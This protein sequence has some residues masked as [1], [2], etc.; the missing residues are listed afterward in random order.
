M[1]RWFRLLQAILILGALALPFAPA[2]VSAAIL[3]NQVIVR[4]GDIGQDDTGYLWEIQYA[5]TNLTTWYSPSS[6]GGTGWIYGSAAYDGNTGTAAIHSGPL[7]GWSENF[8]VSFT[9][10][11]IVGLRF[12]VS[13][14]AKVAVD[15]Y[16]SNNG[17]WRNKYLGSYSSAWNVIDFSETVAT[18]GA[19]GIEST[20]AV[21]QGTLSS[22]GSYS[23]ASVNFQYGTTVNYGQ[24][25]PIETA[26]ATGTFTKIIS[27]LFPNTNYHYRAIARFVGT[28]ETALIFGGDSV[29][30]TQPIA[31]SSTDIRII[32]VGVFSSYITSGDMLFAIE[33]FNNYTNR[34]PHKLPG[35]SFTLQLVDTDNVT[36]LA[37]TP[38]PS[39]GDRPASIYL[40]PTTASTLISG[41]AYYIKMVGNADTSNAT[42]IHILV[43]NEWKGSDLTQLDQW[44]RGV[45]WNV[46]GSE[47]TSIWDKLKRVTGQGEIISD[48]MGPYFSVGIPGI[49]QIRPNLFSSSSSYPSGPSGTDNASWFT[50][51]AWSTYVGP[52]IAADT[53]TMAA[54]FGIGGRDVG[55]AV[56]ALIV[57]ALIVL[58]LQ[59]TNGVGALGAVLLSVPLLWLGMQFRIMHPAVLLLIIIFF[60]LFAIRQFVWKTL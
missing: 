34:Y 20:S 23:V 59:A 50:P 32:S 54:P 29:F 16:D 14:A 3:S 36:I 27:G 31:G 40:N 44:C 52:N 45:A 18:S 42:A 19:A 48:E 33:T 43:A 38:L 1:K 28:N 9:S 57:L 55:A 2:P 21:L 60:G 37:A 47:S 13:G 25:T 8:S 56:L 49:T 41:T 53:T 15:I 12:L 39:W 26:T 17:T 35:E 22:L 7:A 5:T 46:A 6:G 51:G 58:V 30:T 24:E 11:N 4:V 10:A